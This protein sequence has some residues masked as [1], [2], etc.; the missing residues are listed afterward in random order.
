[1]YR[2]ELAQQGVVA[3]TRSTKSLPSDSID[4]QPLEVF[5]ST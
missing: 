3:K 1:M 2:L 5:V 4:N